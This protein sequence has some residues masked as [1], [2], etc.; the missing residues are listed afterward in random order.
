MSRWLV[1]SSKQQEIG[2]AD[3]GPGQEH[4]AFHAGGKGGH[5]G[6]RLE[7]H[8]ERTV[9]I[10]WCMRQ[11]PSASKACW[12]RPNSACKASLSLAGEPARQVM[13]LGQQFGLGAEAPGDLVE[14]RA[15]EVVWHLLRQ[16]RGPQPLLPDD[17]ASIGLQGTLEEAE[18]RGLAGAVAAQEAH[19][20]ARLHRQIGLLQERRAAESQG[21]VGEG[22]EWH[23][24]MIET[25]G[26]FGKPQAVVNG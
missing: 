16:R 13:I 9:S 26:R 3:H 18:E 14:D 5:V 2:A 11:P 23:P 24:W 7:A 22:D 15:L 17:L 20:L 10:C 4:A 8:R 25:A 21:D 6:V 19:P 12:I 1:G